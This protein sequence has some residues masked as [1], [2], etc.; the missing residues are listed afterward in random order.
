MQFADAVIHAPVGRFGNHS[1]VSE[2]EAKV[3]E[4][5]RHAFECP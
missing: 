5:L 2:S 3:I 4:E 1:V